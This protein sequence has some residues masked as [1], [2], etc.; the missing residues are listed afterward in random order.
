M[1]HVEHFIFNFLLTEFPAVLLLDIIIIIII[2]ILYICFLAIDGLT[3]DIVKNKLKSNKHF[4]MNISTFSEV[5]FNKV[6]ALGILKTSN[7]K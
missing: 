6:S 2:I 7:V 1:S 4:K 3:S 5:F